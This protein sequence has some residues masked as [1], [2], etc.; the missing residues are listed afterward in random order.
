MKWP[1]LANDGEPNM[2]KKEEEQQQEGLRR[3]RCWVGGV[4]GWNRR[5]FD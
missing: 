5:I 2:N 1:V 4:T 3:S